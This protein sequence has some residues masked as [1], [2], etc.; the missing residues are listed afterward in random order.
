LVSNY[1]L[2]IW[3]YEFGAL[4]GFAVIGVWFHINFGGFAY[5]KYWE[6][7]QDWVYN[8]EVGRDLSDC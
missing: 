3:N 5:G 1:E 8:T 2:R 4:G 6:V 7:F